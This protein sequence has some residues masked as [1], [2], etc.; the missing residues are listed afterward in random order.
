MPRDSSGNYTLPAGNPVVT[1]TVIS[2]SGWGN[3]T[4]AD[5]GTVLTASLDRSGN[6]GMLAQFKAQD[7]TVSAPGI[8][9]ANELTTGL[10]RIGAGQLG[11]SILG[12]NRIT[13]TSAALSVAASITAINLPG[14]V[15][16]GAPSSGDALTV[17][18]L[19]S[20]NVIDMWA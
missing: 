3:P 16:V 19:G 10:Y 15:I 9:F 17:K 14:N 6:G 5:I 11:I 13:L 8:G 1:G 4:M 20:G 2:S 18:G 7:G 12:A